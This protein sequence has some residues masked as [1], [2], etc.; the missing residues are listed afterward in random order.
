MRRRPAKHDP[1][2]GVIIADVMEP[3][4]AMVSMPYEHGGPG[5]GGG[6]GLGPPDP[7]DDKAAKRGPRA[8]GTLPAMDI[9]NALPKFAGTS[10]NV[11]GSYFELVR[12]WR[13]TLSGG[14]LSCPIGC[15]GPTHLDGGC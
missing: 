5:S 8:A 3:L 13:P 9:G 7:A 1:I 4:R 2:R 6:S 14:Y 12:P 11:E 15:S 10:F